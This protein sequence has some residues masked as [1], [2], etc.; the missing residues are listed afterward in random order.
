MS[1]GVLQEESELV[2][3]DDN[4][5]AGDSKDKKNQDKDQPKD[6]EEKEKIHE[7]LDEVG[8]FL[9]FSIEVLTVVDVLNRVC[10]LHCSGN[11]MRMK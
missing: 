3:K 9:F 7:Q 6:E 8:S 2:A 1:D 11:L 4:T 10:V 5:D